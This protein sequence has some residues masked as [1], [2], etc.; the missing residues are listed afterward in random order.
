MSGTQ[1]E[2]MLEGALRIGLRYFG[3][4]A[5]SA[6]LT[7]AEDGST[8]EH[9]QAVAHAALAAP[10]DASTKDHDVERAKTIEALIESVAREAVE[11]AI[12]RSELKWD[13]SL[14]QTEIDISQDAADALFGEGTCVEEPRL[15]VKQLLAEFQQARLAAANE[16]LERVNIALEVRF[17]A[18]EPHSGAWIEQART[19]CEV[20]EAWKRKLGEGNERV[21]D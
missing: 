18:R 3:G 6:M 12:I 1:R 7:I 4:D 19:A 2:K 11:L 20:I 5:E 14:K 15:S 21:K 13:E 17:A 9:F 8:L 10:A 16:A